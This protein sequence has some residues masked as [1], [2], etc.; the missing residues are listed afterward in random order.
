MDAG[1]IARIFRTPQIMARFALD[2]ADYS[3][4]M[5]RLIKENPLI[6]EVIAEALQEGV[7]DPDTRDYLVLTELC[8]VFIR[9]GKL[10]PPFLRDFAAGAIAGKIKPRPRSG[11]PKNV[12]RD[13]AL[14][15]AT[16]IVAEH[17][18]LPKYSQGN[19][20][21]K[22]TAAEIVA[23]VAG[24]PIDAVLHALRKHKDFAPPILGAKTSP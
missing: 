20:T 9:Q 14:W 8:A 13:F 3:R 15:A 1:Q 2:N 23:E 11:R 21:L 24:V 5:I 16:E 7:K 12:E 17:Y 6:A 10:I 4:H 19:A 18:D 22:T